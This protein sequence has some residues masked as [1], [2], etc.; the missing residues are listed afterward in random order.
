LP[1]SY[2]DKAAELLSHYASKARAANTARTYH[3]QWQQFQEWCGKTG[4][5]HLPATP[6]TIALY[7]AE[8]A[9]AGA[10]VSS[11]AV[12]LA[13]IQFAHDRAGDTLRREDPLLRLVLDGI[14]REHVRPQRQ[15]EPLTQK[16]LDAILGSCGATAAEQR[17]A[18]L[19]ALLFVFAL[20]ASEVVALDW[21][22]LGEGR[23]WLQMGGDALEIGLCGSK[24]VSQAVER[25]VVPTQNCQRAVRAIRN[26]VNLARVE[27]GQPVLR[28]LARGGAIR[29]ERLHANSVSSIIKR[30]VA[31]HLRS[32]GASAES[33]QI[34]AANFSGHSG[35]VGLYV[36]ATE[37]GVPAQHIAALARHKSLCMVLRYAQRADLLTSS[38][39][40]PGVRSACR[41]TPSQDS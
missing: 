37:A 8:R 6:E 4:R 2:D 38:P 32:A 18:A 31:D 15:A 33:A 22:R 29:S 7:L 26:W 12:A 5:S 30:V 34:T 21:I 1:A 27:E 13:A 11:I 39:H 20:R 24:G 36:S 17:G 41:Q 14:R 25:V 35:R 3:T 28:A 23:G 10:A 19:L 40:R 16:L 9:H